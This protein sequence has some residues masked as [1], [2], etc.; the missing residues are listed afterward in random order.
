MGAYGPLVLA[1]SEGVSFC[2]FV[3]LSC[4]LVVFLSFC[5]FAFFHFFIFCLFVF[6]PFCIFAF[7]TCFLFVFL[8]FCLFVTTVII[9]RSISSTIPNF[10]L[11][12]QFFNFTT[13][14]THFTTNFTTNHYHY[15]HPPPKTFSVPKRN[16]GKCFERP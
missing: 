8:S 4:C 15:C 3:L 1:P 13:H 12:Q 2:L 10:V 11:I 9:T 7:L 16:T 6:L 14:F 5:L